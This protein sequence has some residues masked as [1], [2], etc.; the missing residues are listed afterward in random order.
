MWLV[1]KRLGVLTCAKMTQLVS[2]PTLLTCSFFF[3]A[4]TTD[5]AAFDCSRCGQESVEGPLTLP[6]DEG[7]VCLPRV[8]ARKL[9]VYCT[10]ST[11]FI[12]TF[13]TG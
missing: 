10:C 1:C 11:I 4:A 5:I 2:I 7:G 3:F 13:S 8:L 12:L 6:A 9:C